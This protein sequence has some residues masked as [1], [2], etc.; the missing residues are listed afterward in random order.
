MIDII[1]TQ[2]MQHQLVTGAKPP[3]MP[4]LKKMRLKNDLNV[5]R[6]GLYRVPDF[7]ASQTKRPP[8]WLDLPKRTKRIE[9]ATRDHS[10]FVGRQAV[11]DR[12]NISFNHLAERGTTCSL[13]AP[14]NSY[15]KFPSNLGLPVEGHNLCLDI[16]LL[17]S[18][19][20]IRTLSQRSGLLIYFIFPW[21]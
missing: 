20:G 1:S 3:K 2:R 15:W 9:I 10:L 5:L 17:C 18:C 7:P 16:F 14:L 4:Y 12:Q 21:A 11:E 8:P 19:W 13:A 6:S